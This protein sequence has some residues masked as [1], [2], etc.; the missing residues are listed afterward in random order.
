M[1]LKCK[2]GA[3]TIKV[4]NVDPSD[5]LFILLYKLKI[6]D[7]NTKFVFNGTTYSMGSI[8]TFEEIGLTYDAR[9]AVNTQAIAGNI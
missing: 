5:N 8:L 6:S 1:K 2:I 4:I 3:S 9:I 7:K